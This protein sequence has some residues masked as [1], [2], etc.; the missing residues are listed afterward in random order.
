MGM[1][2]EEKARKKELEDNLFKKRPTK[3]ATEHLRWRVSMPEVREFLRLAARSHRCFFQY[4]DLNA[5]KGMLKKRRLWLTRATELNDMKEFDGE[6]DP[7]N[8]FV[9]SFTMTHREN[10]A[11]WWMYA[12]RGEERPLRVP[13]R[14]EFNATGIRKVV[15]G[16]KKWAWTTNGRRKLEVKKVEFFDVLYQLSRRGENGASGGASSA[17]V[18]WNGEF[19]NA[20]RC[21]SAFR[22]ATKA[23]SG[24][25]KE[26][27]W[28]YERETRLVVYL[29]KPLKCKRI[30]IDF[31]P[32]LDTLRVCT[33]PGRFAKAYPGKARRALAKMGCLATVEGSDYSIN[34]LRPQKPEKPKKVKKAKKAKK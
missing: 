2:K 4:T 30:A 3:E 14:L 32:A 7:R 16:A 19:A 25:V 15:D 26:G 18:T 8:A 10:V 1:T 17:A 33:G 20:G 21:P 23:L 22:N 31:G 24:F 34:F 12:L 13:V 11:M 28:E 9:A 5:L 29:K 6:E 27:G